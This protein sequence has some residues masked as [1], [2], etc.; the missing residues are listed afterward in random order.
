MTQ[1]ALQV[2]AGDVGDSS[3]S[4]MYTSRISNKRALWQHRQVTIVT[5]RV[6]RT[7]SIIGRVRLDSMHVLG[8]RRLKVKVIRQG[9]GLGLG[10]GLVKMVK[11]SV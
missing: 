9:Q 6:S 5:D 1:S 11:R 4:R 7:S 10:F 8:H 2:G 3:A